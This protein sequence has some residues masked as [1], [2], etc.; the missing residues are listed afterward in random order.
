MALFGNVGKFFK[1]ASSRF[2]CRPIPGVTQFPTKVNF[3]PCRG[4]LTPARLRSFARLFWNQVTTC[5]FDKPKRF[6]SHFLDEGD[7]YFLNL[8]FSSKASLWKSVK[9]IF[10]LL[11]DVV[12]GGV[13]CL[14]RG[15]NEESQDNPSRWSSWVKKFCT[16]PSSLAILDSSDGE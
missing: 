12:D 13:A 5:C 6:A 3:L 8:K 7:K 11:L 14:A 4:S 10:L 2:L 16:N 9:I 15:L 1:T